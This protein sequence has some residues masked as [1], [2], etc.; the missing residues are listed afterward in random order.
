M[1]KIIIFLFLLVLMNIFGEEKKIVIAAAS[2]LTYVLKELKSD[3]EKSNSNIELEIIFGASGKFATQI[4]EGAPF[5]IFMSA[6]MFFPSSLEKDG[7]SEDKAKI[8]ASGKLVIFTTKNIDIKDGLKILKEKNIKSISICNPETAPYGKATVEALKNYGIFYEIEKKIVKTETVSQVIQQVITSSDIGFTAMSL[9][10]SQDM[11]KYKK[12]VNWIEIDPNL[13]K[14]VEQGIIILKNG[15]N[16]KIS[17][18][19]YEY[20]FSKM[21][22]EIFNKY[23]Y[24]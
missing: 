5:D 7:L 1:K 9:L 2:N 14:K 17:K 21:A 24:E 20:I 18:L 8:Y 13:Y 22:K 16:K 3:F 10:F 6:D 23:G 12:D 4:K 11:A 19:F 15:K